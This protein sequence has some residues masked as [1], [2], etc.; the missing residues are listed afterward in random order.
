MMHIEG[1]MITMFLASV[2]IG[3][4]TMPIILGFSPNVRAH[5]N[6]VYGAVL[7]GGLMALVELLMHGYHPQYQLWLL[8]WIS[9]VVISITMI[10]YQVG[11]TEN[12][13]L[14]GMIEHHAMGIA[15]AERVVLREDVDSATKTLGESIRATQAQ[16]I[17]M[18]DQMLKE[19]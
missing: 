2:V 10:Y 9:V 7:M 17:R 18:M 16:E 12:E 13:F 19:W 15:M 4:L 1:A 11:I 5:K 6:K 3:Y 8:A 14:R